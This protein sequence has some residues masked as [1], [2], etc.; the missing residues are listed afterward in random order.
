MV[1][2]EPDEV[3]ACVRACMRVRAC[4]CVRACVVVCG[5]CVRAAAIGRQF[6]KKEQV[7]SI[8]PQ[9]HDHRMF[10]S[11]DLK[12][13]SR[14]VGYFKSVARSTYCRCTRGEMLAF[15]P[16]FAHA[17]EGTKVGTAQQSLSTYAVRPQYL[18]CQYCVAIH[19]SSPA[20]AQ[21]NM[22]GT[23][24]TALQ[25]RHTGRHPISKSAHHKT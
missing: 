25:P 4:M 8:P 20:A 16:D 21:S 1:R 23:A 5:V 3:L 17:R 22:V 12:F 10:L 11:C 15:V 24:G 19:R 6:H 14:P 2:S 7:A 9:P 13:N 18:S